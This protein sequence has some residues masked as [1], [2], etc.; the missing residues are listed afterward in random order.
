MSTKQARSSL[1]KAHAKCLPW[2]FES[3]AARPKVTALKPAVV[4]T[5]TTT[6]ARRRRPKVSSTG[7]T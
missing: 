1:A 6:R 5:K 2:R 4:T 7:A 3:V